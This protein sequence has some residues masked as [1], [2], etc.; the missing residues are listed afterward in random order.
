MI[1]LRQGGKPVV[2]NEFFQYPSALEK[3]LRG[4]DGVRELE[5]EYSDLNIPFP[6]I[7]PPVEELLFCCKHWKL[8]DHKTKDCTL[9]KDEAAAIKK[10]HYKDNPDKKTNRNR[11]N[12]RRE[13]RTPE[14]RTKL[15]KR[16]NESKKRNLPESFVRR[17]KEWFQRK[18]EMRMK[19]QITTK[20]IQERQLARGMVL[21]SRKKQYA[22]L[23]RQKYRDKVNTFISDH[24]LY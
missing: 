7:P 21:G 8:T 19:F 13:K 12:H 3:A 6:Y 16:K 5:T 17:R 20:E 9:T 14:R 15:N 22:M 18:L 10:K 23:M 4:E 24:L 1:K 2:E 11:E